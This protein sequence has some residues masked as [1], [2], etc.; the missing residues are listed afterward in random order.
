MKFVFNLK[1]KSVLILVVI[2][3]LIFLISWVGFRIFY[4]ESNK[5]YVEEAFIELLEYVESDYE[6]VDEVIDWTAK[7]LNLTLYKF[8]SLEELI[9][10]FPEDVDQEI[11][12]SFSDRQQ[13]EEGRYVVKDLEPTG[14]D[15]DFNRLLFFYP[16]MKNGKLESLLFMFTPINGI[17]ARTFGLSVVMGLVIMTVAG[18]GLFFF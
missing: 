15:V 18:G 11:I 12:L 1:Q 8:N 17:P 16:I 6:N 2:S 4:L 5:R 10:T 7:S 3:L 13:L 14:I 9:A